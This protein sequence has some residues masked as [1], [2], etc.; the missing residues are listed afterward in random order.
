VDGLVTRGL[1]DERVDIQIC[2]L[3]ERVPTSG[4]GEGSQHHRRVRG[5]NVI[6]GKADAA[7]QKTIAVVALAE[8]RTARGCRRS[9][10]V[11]DRHKR[12]ARLVI[13]Y[14]PLHGLV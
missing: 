11:L 12:Y 4:A 2:Q 9:N 10:Q 14:V 13:I 8:K 3:E 1:G 7:D 5:G 6:A